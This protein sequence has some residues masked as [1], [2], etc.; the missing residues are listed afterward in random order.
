MVPPTALATDASGLA[1]PAAIPTGVSAIPV[2]PTLSDFAGSGLYPDAVKAAP[3]P[4]NVSSPK[5]GG[6]LSEANA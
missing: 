3:A 6:K 1:L 2:I 4:V 5:F